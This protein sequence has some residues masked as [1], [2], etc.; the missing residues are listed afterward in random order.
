MNMSLDRLINLAQRTGDRLIIHDPI[1]GRDLVILDVDSYERLLDGRPLRDMNLLRDLDPMPWEEEPEVS[2]WH[3]AGDVLGDRYAEMQKGEEHAPE[4]DITDCIEDHLEEEK[5]TEVPTVD[6][7]RP[8]ERS[9]S[10]GQAGLVEDEDP[11]F[12]EEPV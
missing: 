5:H 11:V 2:P 10:F 4:E 7:P 12:Y 9:Q 8:T 1:Q 6:P 3:T